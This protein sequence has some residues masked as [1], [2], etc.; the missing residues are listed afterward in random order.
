MS[1][2]YIVKI[3]LNDLIYF[4]RCDLSNF[5][6]DA[7]PFV[8]GKNLDFV[9]TKLDE[10]SIIAIEWFE[11][12]NMKM[13]SDKCHVFISGNRCAH[14]WAKFHHQPFFS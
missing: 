1:H 5:V 11:D 2:R 6:D 4:L 14:L 12:N 7:V 10:H 3:Y 13:N 9:F 8:C